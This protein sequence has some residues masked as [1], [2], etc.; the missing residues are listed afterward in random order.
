MEKHVTTTHV[1]IRVEDYISFHQPWFEKLNRAWIEEHFWMEPIDF[2]VLQHPE[3]Y[4]IA[5]GG[6]ILMAYVDKEIAGTVALKYV[7]EGV[8][9]FTKMAVDEKFRGMKVGQALAEAAI[10]KAKSKGARKIILYSSTKLKPALALYRKIGF[11]DVPVDGPY[12]RSDVKMELS[13]FEL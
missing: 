11:V 2:Q 1:S 5:H 3:E 7:Q 9:E 4:I 10:L 8:Y 13:L 12:K 6:A